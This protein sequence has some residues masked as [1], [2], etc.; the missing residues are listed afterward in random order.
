MMKLWQTLRFCIPSAE[1]Q[2]DGALFLGNLSTLPDCLC[3][4]SLRGLQRRR[5]TFQNNRMLKLKQIFRTIHR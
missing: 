1:R 4:C 3:S 5:K 2:G